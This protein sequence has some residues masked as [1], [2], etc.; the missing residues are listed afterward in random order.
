MQAAA[1]DLVQ[2]R[3]EDHIATLTLNRP[4]Q[5]NAIDPAMTR[6]MR[7]AMDRFEGDEAVWVGIL[8]G[9]GDRA[10]CAGMDLKSFAA[11]LGDQVMDEKG[12][13][14]AV[15]RY[16]RTKPL[17]AAVN[18]AALAGGFEIVLSCDLV[19][20]AEKAIFGVPE[21]K[22]GIFAG[23]GG[24]FRLPRTVPRARAMEM[25]L[26]GDPIDAGTALALGLVNSV[27]PLDHLMAA[28]NELARRICVN[29]PLAVRE[30]LAL[31]R[32]AFDAP[33][34]ELW[35]RNQDAWRRINET[36]DAKEGPLAFVEK[37]A[38]V[39]KAR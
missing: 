1:Q 11:G 31:A 10:F 17:I 12:G 32:A 36:A 5:R 9:A 27:V 7:A 34:E 3:V 35:R 24:A 21:V 6:A 19:V 23:A 26:T 22:R 4:D 18:G 25:L 8:T 33:E 14:A 38:P 13:F 28:A 37:R 15:T 16:P 2:V 29:A 39:W 30:A 20:A